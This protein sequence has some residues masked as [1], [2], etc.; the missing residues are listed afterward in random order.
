ME[1]LLVK[2]ILKSKH[3]LTVVAASCLFVN[4]AVLIH[5]SWL[6]YPHHDRLICIW[7]DEFL[8]THLHLFYNPSSVLIH[9]D[10]PLSSS[11]LQVE[12]LCKSIS[13]YHLS[14]GLLLPL[15]YPPPQGSSVLDM[16][17]GSSC[18]LYLIQQHPKTSL[19]DL[20]C[21]STPSSFHPLSLSRF[22]FLFLF[23][24]CPLNLLRFRAFFHGQP[25]LPM[26]HCLYLVQQ[27]PKSSLV[28]DAAAFMPS[29]CYLYLIQ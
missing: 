13:G 27:W 5:P 9:W 21:I 14:N 10:L 7:Y 28:F 23:H 25:T 18:C 20:T 8:T 15:S 1:L 2:Y 16:A 6:S 11:K 24:L 12:S 22:L 29:N 17:T 3:K 4:K 19:Q 26:T